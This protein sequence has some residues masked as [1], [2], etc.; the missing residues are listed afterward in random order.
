M[1]IYELSIRGFYRKVSIRK[2]QLKSI[3]TG[4]G[5]LIKSLDSSAPNQLSYCSNFGEPS[6]SKFWTHFMSHEVDG[7]DSRRGIVLNFGT[8]K[9]RALSEFHLK[10]QWTSF[11]LSESFE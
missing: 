5:E 1:S 8:D 7:E 10:F 4:Q 11:E 2:S 9:L 6:E 3:A